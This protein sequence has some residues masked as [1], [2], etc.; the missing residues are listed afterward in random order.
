MKTRTPDKESEDIQNDDSAGL[1]ACA[2]DL[3]QGVSQNDP[4]KVA[5]AIKSAFIILE[6]MPHDEVEPHSYDAQKE[7]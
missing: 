7:D 1:E 4:K 3:I 6:S 2:N 5:E